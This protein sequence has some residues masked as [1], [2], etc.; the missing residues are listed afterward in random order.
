M[1][2]HGVERNTEPSRDL[3]LFHMLEA[4]QDENGARALGKLFQSNDQ[5]VERLATSQDLFGIVI[6]WRVLRLLIEIVPPSRAD[7]SAAAQVRSDIRSGD[8]K[9]AVEMLD[10][11]SQALPLSKADKDLLRGVFIIRRPKSLSLEVAQQ[12]GPVAAREILD[13][14]AIHLGIWR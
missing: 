14:V 4:R 8:E 3:S 5:Y 6:G 11:G 9:V 13:R 2:F 10:L 7:L 1:L 12:A